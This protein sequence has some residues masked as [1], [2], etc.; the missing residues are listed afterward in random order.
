MEMAGIF[1]GNLCLDWQNL[2]KC[3]V[4]SACF[5]GRN[6]DV[7]VLMVLTKIE[8]YVIIHNYVFI[9]SVVLLTACR[10]LFIKRGE[11]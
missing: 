11:Y 4:N 10:K 9:K 2:Y 6:V 7:S 3:A 8:F 5:Q 1:S